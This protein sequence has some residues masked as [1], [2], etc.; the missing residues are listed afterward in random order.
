MSELYIDHNSFG[1]ESYDLKIFGKNLKYLPNL[2]I[3]SLGIYFTYIIL[4]GCG[5]KI[6][7][8]NKYFKYIPELVDLNLCMKKSNC[9]EVIFRWE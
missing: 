9:S 2:R 6:S 3:L 1:S 4:A 8:L 7:K 5:I